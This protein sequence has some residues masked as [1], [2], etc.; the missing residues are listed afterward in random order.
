MELKKPKSFEELLELQKVLDEEV[1]KRRNNNFIPRERRELDIFLS[2]DDEFQEWLRELPS[3]YNFK[4]WKQKVYSREKEI[5]EFTDCLFFFAQYQN[6]L[7]NPNPYEYDDILCTVFDSWGKFYASEDLFG[8]IEKFK[9]YLWTSDYEV[10]FDSW[11][12][13]SKLRGFTKQE[14]LDTY[15]NKWQKNIKRIKEDWTLKGD[16]K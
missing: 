15:W 10:C 6:T 3:E 9:F 13:I 2:L 14:I 4:T 1:S 16:E 8:E 11:I 5:E 12:A 7:W